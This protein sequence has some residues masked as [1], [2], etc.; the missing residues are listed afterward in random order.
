MK[1]ILIVL[2]GLFKDRTT[3]IITVAGFS[4][5]I[6]MALLMTAFLIS[7]FS[8]DKAY[9]NSDRIYRVFANDKTA[10][11][12]EDFREY[13]LQN[14]PSVEDACRFNSFG[15]T[16]TSDERPFR[17]QMIC[18]DSSFFNI[19]SIRFIAGN[20]ASALNG[21]NDIVLTQSFSRKIFGNENPLGKTLVAEYRD[22]LIVTAVVEDFPASSSIRGD[23]FTNSETKIIYEGSSDGNG[24]DVNY[25]REFIL[26]RQ[27][28]NIPEL[29]N[30]LT[31]DICSHKYEV[32]YTI[33]KI[34]LVPFRRSYFMQGINRSQTAH[35]NVRLIRLLS[36][37]TF[38][39]ILLA[40]FNYIN[41]VTATHTDRFMEIAVRKTLGA[42][43]SLIFGQFMGESIIISL[44]SFGIAVM[45][46]SLW[47]PFFEN[48]VG[49]TIDMS[50][51]YS[52]GWL[53]RLIAGILIISFISGI[54]P[55]LRV[56]A[57][58]PV[59]IMAKRGLQAQN[60]ISLRAVLNV[61]QY[62]VSVGLIIAV[63]VI[64]RQI[65]FVRTRDFGFD[66]DKLVRVD[67]HWQM[68]DKC[69]VL[70]DKLL[71]VSGI[72]GLSFSHG[73]PGSIYANSSWDFQGRE[74]LVSDLTVD[75]AFF[76]V[77]RIP[78]ISGREPRRSDFNKVCYINETAFKETGWDSY[79]GKKY[80]G[81]EI[82][83]IVK[84][85]NFESLYN[86]ITPLVIAL[87]SDMGIS[88]MTL[89]INPHNMPGIISA[90][91]EVWK[92]VCPSYE[93]KYRFYDEWLNSMYSGE[94]KLAAA[95]RMFS[96]FAILIACLGIFGLAEF[97]IKRRT[98]EIGLRKVN[99]ARVS[100]VMVLL[101]RDFIKWVVYS[102]AIATPVS[103]FLLNKW[104][105]N[106][107]YRTDLSWWIFITGG[108]IAVLIALVT[109]SWQSLRAATRN[110][111][112]ALRYE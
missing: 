87:S 12:R 36:A 59:T 42:S 75:S 74:C 8:T 60:P 50:I 63:I 5:S 38:L 30:L 92:E 14:Y 84:D 16:L 79:E 55:A 25:F 105:Q 78:V 23:F 81:K 52:P 4:V 7:E 70:R 17:G 20:S 109:V 24:H 110:P 72:E 18:T 6:S 46:S 2:R 11:V 65:D 86:R 112:E 39:I 101:N 62:I 96:V 19:F 106:F 58:K 61:F 53:I 40:V 22:P 88:H 1:S 83:G 82:I 26:V 57:Q 76:S 77:F 27:G 66:T 97:S 104:L 43:R 100:Q 15:S 33:E 37:I 31:A 29:Q 64:S 3:S 99:G 35:A 28:T 85:F 10:S 44:M 71:G 91:T 56:S 68:A 13:F 90:L 21:L 94:E 93:L 51:L 69:P 54:Y 34:N 98:K 41:L 32:G 48:F 107:A 103:W 47:L 45:L 9:P 102:I 108:L 73:T 80:H 49:K 89:R 67:I 95:I 111:V